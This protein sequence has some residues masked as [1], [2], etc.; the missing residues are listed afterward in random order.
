[1][2]SRRIDPKALA[3]IPKKHVSPFNPSVNGLRGLCVAFV[4][5]FHVAKSGL[6]PMPPDDSIWQWDIVYL[7]DSW[8]YFVEVFFMISGYVIVMSLR[9][10]PTMRG[11]LFDRFVRIFPLWIPVLLSICVLGPLLGWR[12]LQHLDPLGWLRM[13]L[14]NLMLLPPLVPDVQ[15][16]HPA[17]WSLSYE[18]LFYLIAA[19]SVALARASRVPRSV[20]IPVSVLAVLLGVSSFPRA[21]FFLSGVAVAFFGAAPPGAKR[22]PWLAP[23][24]LLLFLLLWR[25]TDVDEAGAGSLNL[26][27]LVSGGDGPAMLGAFAA[28]TYFFACVAMPDSRSLALLR[29]RALQRLGTISYSFYLCHPLVMF[30]VKRV[31]KTTMP[32][33]EGSWAATLVFTLVSA[34]LSLA[35]A[36]LCWRW[37]EKGLGQWLHAR[38]RELELTR[39]RV[40]QAR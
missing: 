37:I 39:S 8:S 21:I 7:V 38:K 3:V 26:W 40:A 19:F 6:P 32:H 23:L 11:F 9:R 5:L 20:W 34:V 27:E 28:A 33:A 12:A 10:H 16:A 35:L 4:F 31:V 15:A 14:A 17:S 29:T 36:W 24:A 22:M 1:M 18:W 30:A 25:S 13:L 2:E